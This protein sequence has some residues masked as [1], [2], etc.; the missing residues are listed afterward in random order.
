M[1]EIGFG[2]QVDDLLDQHVLLYQHV[3]LGASLLNAHVTATRG[4]KKFS[5]EAKKEKWNGIVNQEMEHDVTLL[6]NEHQVLDAHRL[7]QSFVVLFLFW[8]AIELLSA[9]TND[10]VDECFAVV[11]VNSARGKTVGEVLHGEGIVVAVSR[12]LHVG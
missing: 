6:D 7:E 9:E 5:D 4:S 3:E 11:H 12:D 2:V 1:T 8:G 10:L